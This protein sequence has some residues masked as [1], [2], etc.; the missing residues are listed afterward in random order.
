[1]IESLEEYERTVEYANG[2]QN[3]LLKMRAAQE[4]EQYQLMSRS[5]LK[6][7][8]KAQREITLYLA[9]VPSKEKGD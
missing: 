4:P 7:L 1:M 5:Y 2:L 6:D 8:A 9:V 3:W